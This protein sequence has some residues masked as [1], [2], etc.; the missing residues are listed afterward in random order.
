MDYSTLLMVAAIIIVGYFLMVRPAQ[1]RQAEQ[2]KT[3]SELQPG[4]R[5]MLASGIFATIRHTGERQAVVEIAPGIE[6]TILKAAIARTVPAADEEFEY[7]GEDAA[8]ETVE[9]VAPVEGE[10][11]VE[12]SDA[13]DG[14][15]DFKASPQTD[16]KNQ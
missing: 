3:L 6:M 16:P 4:T 14:T 13:P 15:P 11:I 2:Q 9:P 8:D 1:K 10:P 7:D 5:V 12:A